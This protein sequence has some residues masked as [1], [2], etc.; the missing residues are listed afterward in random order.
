MHTFVE[1]ME[2]YL[3]TNIYQVKQH[4]L[5]MHMEYGE[6]NKQLYQVLDKPCNYN[7]KE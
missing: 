4:I 2:Q 7:V 5:D 3:L 1:I 6:L